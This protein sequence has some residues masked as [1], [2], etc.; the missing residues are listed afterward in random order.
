MIYTLV[1]R[2]WSTFGSAITS[3]KDQGQGKTE[4]SHCSTNAA[5]DDASLYAIAEA[6]SQKISRDRVSI[7]RDIF[8]DPVKSRELL[9]TEAVLVP[10]FKTFSE[11]LNPLRPV[12]RLPREVLIRILTLV[13]NGAEIVPA[14]HVCGQWRAI[15]LRCPKLWTSIR[16]AELTPMLPFFLE[17][18]QD[19]ALDV[20]LTIDSEDSGRLERLTDLPFSRLRSFEIVISGLFTDT[21]K[22]VLARL[23]DPAPL[24][25]A[26]A[27]RFDHDTKIPTPDSADA[28]DTFTLLFN[29]ELP[30]LSAVSFKALRPWSTLLSEILT[31]LTLASLFISANDLYPCL[32]SVPN[33]ELL[34]LL[35][36]ISTLSD[37]YTGGADPVPLDRLRTLYIHQPGGPFKHFGHLMS[38]LQ[39]PRLEF[40]CLLMGE[41]D[42]LDETFTDILLQPVKLSRALT[43]VV[44]QLDGEPAAK[45][46]L[47]ATHEDDFIVSMCLPTPYLPSIFNAG[48][49]AIGPVSCDT[50]STTEFILR[51]DGDNQTI[52][53]DSLLHVLRCLPAIEALVVTGMPL[54]SIVGALTQLRDELQTPV[55][56][57]LR[58]F[59]LRGIGTNPLGLTRLLGQRLESGLPTP[60]VVCPKS[61]KDSVGSRFGKIEA[62]EDVGAASFPRPLTVPK[63]M[64]AFLTT[65][66][67]Q[68]EL[69]W[70]MERNHWNWS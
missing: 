19:S 30:A 54:D 17:R 27:I 8:L 57:R 58:D 33:L 60:R 40:T 37:D 48:V 35:N 24:L 15:A 69:D 41:C 65:N 5:L 7:R 29:K 10:A 49:I 9:A 52:T 14:S 46:Y 22:N 26:L 50:S 1:D 38:H 13:G 12:Q 28:G 61:L 6:I 42:A 11:I 4:A 67:E 53:A 20:S 44:L 21:V 47:H 45:F 70:L 16:D 32:K 39:F 68:S 31:S 3:S 25:T 56:P 43:K 51:A 64:Q 18:S 34:A 36:V 59:Y 66:L 23:R 62:I 63:S 55:L 2:L